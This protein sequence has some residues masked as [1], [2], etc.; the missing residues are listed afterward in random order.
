M[1]QLV[2][3][4]WN[5]HLRREAR[6]SK[7]A[8]QDGADAAAPENQLLL[9][10]ATAPEKEKADL[11]KT[12]REAAQSP[13]DGGKP[14]EPS[15]PPPSKSRKSPTPSFKREG[16]RSRSPPKRSK[17]RPAAVPAAVD[18]REFD[19]G[20]LSKG[21]LWTPDNDAAA[22]RARPY[23]KSNIASHQ[24]QRPSS[25]SLTKPHRQPHSLPAR[26]P[27]PPPAE[28]DATEIIKQ[29]ETR[30]ISQ[31]QLVAEVKGIYAGLVMVESKCI[32][33]DNNQ[34]SQSDP[35]NKLNNDQWQALIALHRT[36]LHEHHDFFL[37]SQHPSASPALRRLAAKYAMPARMWRHGI[38]SFLELLR[39]R[40]PASLDHMLTFIYM[41]YS[42][43]ALLYETVPAFEDTW[44]ECL[45]DLGRYRM[46]IE[47]DDIRDREVWTAVSRHWYSRA[48]DKAP[49][50]GRLYHHLAILARPNAMQQLYYYS[51]SLCVE[52]PFLSA[53]ESIMTLFEPLISRTSNPQ[54]ARLP[55]TELNFGKTHGILFSGKQLEE[56]EP[57]MET[58]FQL[59]DNHIG[60]STRRW[61]EAGYHMA[62]SNICGVTGY[63]DDSNPITAAL[64]AFS[65][66]HPKSTTESQDQPMQD[67]TA[68]EA[69]STPAKHTTPV[70]QQ[71]PNALRLLAGTYDIVARRFGDRNI[72]PF[73]HVTLVFVHHLTFCPDAMA[74]VAPVFPWKLTAFMLNTLL[75]GSAASS[76]SAQNVSQAL[77]PLLE[78]EQ[79]PGS[80]EVG[81]EV[82]GDGA[83]Q[84]EGAIGVVAAGRR[85]RPL[86]DDFAMRGF[87]WVE[88]YFP[89]KWFDTD[90]KI[91]DDEKY[92]ELQSMSEERRERVVWLGCR[93][94]EREGGRWL[95]FDK[96]AKRFGVNPA[97][98]V[99]LDL[100][101]PGQ[102]LPAT[103]GESVDYGELP[104]AGTVA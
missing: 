32:E 83:K 64:K 15:P 77:A 23:D 92:F 79:F 40:L 8:P 30:P 31:E 21:T 58:F 75:N 33:V 51:K 85:K 61:L 69:P 44:I 46:A 65:R 47:D 34:S 73:L 12:Q 35:A 52:M 66:A 90:E 84:E 6:K 7:A 45:G 82:S 74:H 48:S 94:A 56:L 39:H 57:T 103:P 59:L 67:A 76:S 101:M 60:R 96:E 80:G 99:E 3:K 91:D 62:I 68:S 86:P 50:T 42:M 1:D 26:G 49:T 18:N 102:T 104:D 28:D 13:G 5:E 27:A 2:S 100:E 97:Y 29:P 81:K 78:G 37:A 20:A 41:A 89:D 72:L 24:R 93:I 54:Q 71:L 87:P 95:R 14:S 36:L 38:H 9:D 53:R 25:G 16:S 4:R 11:V 55:P 63:G 22:P 10:K 98:E 17:A 88:K 19:R 43:M 70:K